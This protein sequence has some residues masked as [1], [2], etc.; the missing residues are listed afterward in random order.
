MKWSTHFY[1]NI[2]YYKHVPFIQKIRDHK[3]NDA[4]KTLK[5]YHFSILS[6]VSRLK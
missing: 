5:K 6:F 4:I 3:G 2:E 1:I